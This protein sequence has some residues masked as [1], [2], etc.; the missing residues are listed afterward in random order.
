M[1]RFSISILPTSISPALSSIASFPSLTG[2]CGQLEGPPGTPSS[3]LNGTGANLFGQRF[4]GF[5]GMQNIGTS[6]QIQSQN[7]EEKPSFNANLTWVKG[8]HTFK[9]GAEIVL[10]ARSNWSLF[11]CDLG[12]ARGV[13]DSGR[14]IAAATAQPYVSYHQLQRIQHGLRIRQF[15][16]GRLHL[17]ERD[18]ANLQNPLNFTRQ[19]NQQWGLFAQDSWK[20]TA[21][22]DRD[23]RRTLGLCDSLSRAV[24]PLGTVEWDFAES[25]CGWGP[26]R[27]SVRLQLQL[28]L[29]QVCLSFRDWT[30]RGCGL[31]DYTEDR[32]SRWVGL[33]LSV[34]SKAAGAVVAIPGLYP[35]S[36]VNP[37]VN[38]A[39]PGAIVTPT[40]PT[41]NPGAYP[42]PG[43]VGAPT[44]RS[45]F[46][47]ATKTGR[48]AST[49]SASASSRRLPRIS[50]CKPPL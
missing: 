4:S 2:L 30:A 29:L 10:G 21:Q 42:L 31:S 9:F 44:G 13:W 16:A 28:Q 36:G 47:M 11:R 26:G 19:G 37:Y 40:W 18:G 17:R 46:R 50:S 33:H 15:P 24:W 3:C 48:R 7:Y 1:R 27:Y 39:T 14:G 43:T 32:I 34:R 8:A 35:L 45:L 6:G 12:R 25:Q 20:V 22:S 23:L 49:S 38:I 41:T 5:G